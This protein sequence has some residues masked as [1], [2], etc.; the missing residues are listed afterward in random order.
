MQKYEMHTS[1][2]NAKYEMQKELISY[3]GLIRY[4]KP[5]LSGY[6]QGLLRLEPQASVDTAKA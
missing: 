1:I 3:Q 4:R 2:R 5:S 6:Y